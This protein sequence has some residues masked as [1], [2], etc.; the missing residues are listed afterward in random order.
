MVRFALTCC[1]LI[2]TYSIYIEYINN[3]MQLS[4]KVNV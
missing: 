1:D 3:Y 4:F 2:Y